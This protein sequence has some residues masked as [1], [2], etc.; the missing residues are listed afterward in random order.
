MFAATHYGGEGSALDRGGA[1]VEE[2]GDDCLVDPW[3]NP[4]AVVRSVHKLATGFSDTTT[5]ED[6]AAAALAGG[7]GEARM[8]DWLLPP[9]EVSN[10]K[11]QHAP[12]VF[13]VGL[14][15]VVREH[16]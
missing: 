16:S 4:W 2:G 12:Q 8:W 7:G 6:T 5:T 3:L 10:L 15:E 9:H 14:V 11:Q 1:P 13:G